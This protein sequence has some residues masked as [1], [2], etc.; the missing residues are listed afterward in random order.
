MQ[1]KIYRPVIDLVI[2]L[3]GEGD[4]HQ[5]R[6][7]HGEDNAGRAGGQH[8]LHARRFPGYLALLFLEASEDEEG[9]GNG[10]HHAHQEAGLP[11]PG[12]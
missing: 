5:Y 9:A 3:D 6:S 1:T 10:Q 2:K 11:G 7:Q 4:Q 8:D 12:A